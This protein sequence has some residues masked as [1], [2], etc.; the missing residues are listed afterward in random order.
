MVR[1]LVHEGIEAVAVELDAAPTGD[2]PAGV[3]AMA[4]LAADIM[5]DLWQQRL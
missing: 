2:D 1:Q 5:V 4:D 3:S